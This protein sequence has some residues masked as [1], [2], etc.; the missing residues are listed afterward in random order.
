M[1]Q[2]LESTLRDG[3][4]RAAARR[5]ASSAPTGDRRRGGVR[6]RAARPRGGARPGADRQR[7]RPAGRGAAAPRPGEHPL[8]S[9]PV[10]L[11][12]LRR[13]ASRCELAANPGHVGGDAG[14]R[15]HPA[16][17]RAR[18]GGRRDAPAR[19]ATSTGCS[20]VD[21]DQVA[22]LTTARRRRS[23]G[24]VRCRRSAPSSSTS[25][26]VASTPTRRRARR[27]PLPR[28]SAASP[29]SRRRRG[30]RRARPRPRP[31][32]WA[33]ASAARRAHGTRRRPSRCSRP[34]AGSG[35]RRH[36]RQRTASGCRASIA[37]RPSRA[38]LLA[39]A[40]RRGGA[41]ARSA[42][43]SCRSGSWTCTGDLL[44][45]QLQWPN[46]FDTV[47]VPR[48]AG[49]GPGQRHGSRSRAATRRA[50]TNP[51]DANPGGY[52]SA[53]SPTGS[54]AAA[55]ATADRLRAR[56]STAQVQTRLARD[57]PGLP[58]LVRRRT[59][60]AAIRVRRR[61]DGRHRSRDAA[62]LVGHLRAGTLTPS[63]VTRPTM[64]PRRP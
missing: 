32:S 33:M 13:P 61:I 5:S 35:A 26:R 40:Q 59:E 24:A 37:V 36:L 45:A 44:L 11:D 60:R 12:E 41:A 16:G 62:L 47:L 56:A 7:H 58:H 42:A 64:T 38:D 30:G 21:A 34:P 49:H 17:H 51:A 1:R 3:E 20:T 9:G 57:L 31:G 10:P 18:P 50:P 27:S 2:Q 43:S 22:A 29:R 55:R 39:F 14:D 19:P 25:A 46:D 53:R 8:G 15:A 28:P 23:S 52:A 54:S 63:R 6:G 4:P 48:A